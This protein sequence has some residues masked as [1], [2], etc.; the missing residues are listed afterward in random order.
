[1]KYGFTWHCE[2]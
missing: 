1:M 2:K